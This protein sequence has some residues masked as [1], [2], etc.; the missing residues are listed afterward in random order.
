M[1][2]LL[3]AL[4]YLL[5]FGTDGFQNT[6]SS[7][8]LLLRCERLC[9]GISYNGRGDAFGVGVGL[10]SATS[11]AVADFDERGGGAFDG[12]SKAAVIS[13]GVMMCR[14]LLNN[15]DGV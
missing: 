9:C 5:L 11:V 1:S 15:A 3:F 14:S 2:S 12:I 10:A 13:L 6:S 8:L 4:F 7:R